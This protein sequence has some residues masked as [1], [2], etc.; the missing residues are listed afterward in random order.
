MQHLVGITAFKLKLAAIIGMTACHAGYV[1]ADLL[2][3]PL[4]C[5]LQACGG[6]TFPI[7]AFLLVEG[8][9]H[10]SSRGRYASRLLV[11][12]ILSQIPYWLVLGWN[13]NVLFT[14][15]L[16]LWLLVLYDTA[17]REHIGW[18]VYVVLLVAALALSL[19]LDWGFIGPIMVLMMHTEKHPLKRIA[20]P[21]AVAVVGLGLPAVAEFAASLL[22]FE[23]S[24]AAWSVLPDMLYALV[25]I[26]AAGALLLF[27][28]GQRGK[29]LKWFFYSY[30]PTHIAFLG[31]LRFAIDLIGLASSTF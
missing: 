26:P 16:S 15:L 14:L 31:M 9:K 27:Y 18:G 22:L 13:G 5:I 23:G 8:Y 6:I 19:L 17:R 25:G 7:M 4:A 29:S 30:Y 1:F 11:F 2:P 24:A 20:A 21:L 3:F 12:A 28:R 10:T